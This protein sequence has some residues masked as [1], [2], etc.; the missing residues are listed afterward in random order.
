[1]ERLESSPERKKNIYLSSEHSMYI[2]LHSFEPITLITIFLCIQMPNRWIFLQITSI[3]PWKSENSKEHQPYHF[4]YPRHGKYAFIFVLFNS[5][6][7]EKAVSK[8]F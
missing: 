7:Q 1:M 2:Y 3:I 8:S 6:A 4:H 5:N